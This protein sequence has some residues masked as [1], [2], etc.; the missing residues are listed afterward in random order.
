MKEKG[1]LPQDHTIADRS[2]SLLSVVVLMYLFTQSSGWIFGS[3]RNLQH[4]FPI[5]H[6]VA[7]T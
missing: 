5:N 6:R 7:F 3:F 1:I 4:C 2:Q